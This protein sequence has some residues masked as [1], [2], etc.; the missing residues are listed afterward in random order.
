MRLHVLGW[1][2]PCP[3]AG[4][5]L[6]GY[7][8][9][10]AS[11]EGLLLDLGSGSLSRLMRIREPRGLCGI[12][13][14][15]LHW[16]HMS[17]MLPLSYM[18]GMAGMPVLAQE[19]PVFARKALEAGPWRLLPHA[20]CALGPFHIRF[21][22]ARHPVPA[23]CVRIECEGKSFVYTGDTNTVPG[24]ADFCRGADLLLADAG[25]PES[26]YAPEKPHLSPRLC[27]SLAL[28]AGAKRLV[29]THLSPSAAPE[30]V[31]A[32][33]SAYPGAICAGEGLLVEF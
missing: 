2:G 3:G 5:A 15:H 7:L 19:E 28:E 29:L 16:D 9:E 14:T 8:L 13:L 26:V 20:E 1:Q 17:D 23:S 4:G 24:L 27:A 32:E 25:L 30:G 33:A 12:I 10:A 31:L 21:F 11:G 18:A 22:A 6:S